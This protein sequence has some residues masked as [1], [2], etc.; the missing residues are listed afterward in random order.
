[1]NKKKFAR[2]VKSLICLVREYGIQHTPISVEKILT[3]HENWMQFVQNV[4]RGFYLAQKNVV[5]LLTKILTERKQLKSELKDARRNKLKEEIAKISNLIEENKYQEMVFRKVMDAIA[6]QL[7]HYDLSILKR[8]YGGEELID[9]TDSNL[10]SE[11]FAVD[12]FLEEDPYC[13][14]LISD[15][16]TFIQ[17]GDLIVFRPDKG[18]EI[19]ELKD[20]E[21]N[22]FMIC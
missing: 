6:W 19:Y 20:G 16:T 8:L 3:T 9:I 13:F 4:H 5:R 7:F 14:V 10:E 22:R 11:L 18:L 1:M 17:V 21:K 2:E 12:R 15:L